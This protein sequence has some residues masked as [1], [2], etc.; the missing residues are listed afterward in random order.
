MK[1]QLG[2]ILHIEATP[3]RIVCLVPSLTEL[4]VDLGL[5]SKLL[6][7]T[8][9]CVHPEHIR[10][11]KTI[12]GGTKHLKIDK[13]MELKPDFILANKEENNKE[14]VESLSQN[15]IVY[16]SDI[17]SIEDLYQ[18][19][20]DIENVFNVKEYSRQ[21]ID[22]MEASFIKFKREIQNLPNLKVAYFIWK[23]PWMVVGSSTFIHYILGL[24]HFK[25]VYADVERYPEI[26]I[27]HLKDVDL[28]LLSSEP[29]PFKAKHKSEIPAENSIIKIVDGE[30]FSW[31][32]SRLIK[33]FSYFSNLRDNL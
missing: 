33:A 14:D 28:V 30:F 27:N 29:F 8:K 3:K 6:G 21:L 18:L 31:Y 2:R 25:N 19:I 22:E 20:K 12:I 23:D 26:E 1:D 15:S 32:G 4:L 11:T 16:V 13:I 10:T 24:C 9:F 7:V 17:R 5:E